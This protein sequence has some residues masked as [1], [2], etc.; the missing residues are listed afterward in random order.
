VSDDP[1]AP[2]VLLPQKDHTVSVE[3]ETAWAPELVSKFLRTE[4][5]PVPT[6]S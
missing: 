2:A 4:K 3:Q 5:Y 1:H 6:G